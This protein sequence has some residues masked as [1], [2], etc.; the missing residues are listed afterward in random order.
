MLAAFLSGFN[1]CHKS[2]KC[3]AGQLH[4]QP[5]MLFSVANSTFLFSGRPNSKI[6]ICEVLVELSML[7]TETQS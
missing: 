7:G 2:E 6:C 4:G 5:D 1:G 3:F